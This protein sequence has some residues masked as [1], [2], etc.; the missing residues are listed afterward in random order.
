MAKKKI[1]KKLNKKA[2]AIEKKFKKI[3]KGN[4]AAVLF[5]KIAA[6]AAVLIAYGVHNDNKVNKKID[7]VYKAAGFEKIVEEKPSLIG[8]IKNKFKKQDA[9]APAPAPEGAATA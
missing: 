5:G 1:V 2:N 6:P 8:K 7:E 4:E 9:P 3:K